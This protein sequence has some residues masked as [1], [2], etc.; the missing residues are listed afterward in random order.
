MSK[1]K[2]TDELSNTIIAWFQN[3]ATTTDISERI[4]IDF[5]LHF[6]RCAVMG[7]LHR[8]GCLRGSRRRSSPQRRP[9]TRTKKADTPHIINCSQRPV[10]LIDARPD[11][12]R[13]PVGGVRDDFRFCGAP[14]FDGSYCQHHARMAYRG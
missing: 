12:C 14:Q 7:R 10:S 13:W 8:L 2:W 1:R 6:T 5:D 3:G 11:D 9:R 4:A